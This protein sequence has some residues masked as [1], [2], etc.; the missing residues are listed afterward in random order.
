MHEPR[1]HGLAAVGGEPTE[2]DSAAVEFLARRL[3]NLR[4]LSGV[5][6]LRMVRELPGGGYVIAQNMGGVFKAITHKPGIPPKPEPFDGIAKDY[7]P[8]L[9]SGV[10]TKAI[11]RDKEGL[12]MK[13]TEQCRKRIAGYK[14]KDIPAKEVELQRFS[15]EYAPLFGEFLPMNA[16][17]VKYTQYAAQRPTWYSGAMAEVMQIV[18]GY[19]RQD[20]EELP[21][22]RI[23]RAKLLLPEKYKRKIL[24]E[25]GGNVRLPGYTGFPDKKG[26]FKYDYKFHN[27]NGVS[28]DDMGRPWLLRVSSAGVHAMPL[29]LVP[30]T[31]TKAF[32]EWVEETG[33]DEIL[34][35][36][37]RFGGMPSGEGMPTHSKAFEAWRRA[38]VIIKVCDCADF[39]EHIMYSSAIGW[40]FNSSGTEGYNTC[41]D[42]YDDEGLGYGLAYKMKITLGAA[43]ND[44]K[45]PPS[46]DLDDS[47]KARRL[48]AYLS[49]IY[50]L[51]TDNEPEHLA[52]KYKIRR[53]P[54]SDILSRASLGVIGKAELD[55]WNGK[56]VD[57][58][59]VHSGSVSEVGRGYLYNAA[60]FMY[61]PQIK[62][63]E[64]FL[65]GCVSHD[66]LPLINGR[67]KE[68]YPNS[69]TIMFGYYVGDDLK[70]V[71]YFREGGS[72]SKDVETD[73]E[74]C[75][76]VGSWTQ[77]VTEGST[78]L[79]GNFYTSDIDDRKEVSDNVTITKIKG[80]DRGYSKEPSFSF[81][82][83][84]SMC[85]TMW[86]QRYYEHQT[87]T[88]KS[89]GN[90]LSVATC[91]PYLDRNAVIHAK[92]EGI[93]GSLNTTGNALYSVTDPNSYRYFT[94]DFVMAWV[95]CST[96]GNAG[97]APNVNP[98]PRD[99]NPVW[100]TGYN[101]D[102]G[103]C[104]DFADQGDWVGGLPSDYT[105]LIHPNKKE[106]K[107]SGGGGAPVISRYST[108]VKGK[109]KEEGELK[110]SASASPQLIN[111]EIPSNMYFLGSPDPYVGVFYRDG[112]RITFGESEYINVSESES[113]GSPY[114]KRWGFTNLADHKSAH[115][116]IG[117]INE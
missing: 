115:H 65:G 11:L 56:E 96:E 83:F 89:E 74:E 17:V 44:G 42:Y 68:A 2:E 76:T 94:Y 103:G 58:I 63:P 78:T 30:A 92:K 57:P 13:L 116:F 112:C 70:V 8:M 19:G 38:G 47:D 7:I 84:F 12:R 97:Y 98:Y 20:L 60:K 37:D 113:K 34:A 48:D 27:T 25:M 55:Y 100:V 71:K 72:Y 16:T 62:F 40:S 87:E 33:D 6:S 43:M 88:F 104:S 117:V 22:T 102:P 4:N 29:P 32:R 53:V 45:L 99:G 79:L 52:I 109:E 90:Y 110:Y 35:M 95:G 111:K 66:F 82:D 61:Q 64:P 105:W 107:H 31:T 50:R 75:M 46:F 39:Y 18:G 1:P 49:G 67:Y 51:M 28:F 9:F 14:S 73:F 5:D 114:R 81:D 108:S 15:I 101:Y 77:I 26:Q 54:I 86:R 85:G 3:T 59:A 41:Y 80:I 23:E 36:L 21:D 69:D 91:V 10:V 93:T 106:W 24:D